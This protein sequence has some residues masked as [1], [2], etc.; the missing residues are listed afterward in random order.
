MDAQELPDGFR[1]VD[2][3]AL[4]LGVGYVVGL[5]LRL[6]RQRTWQDGY[7]A[8]AAGAQLRARLIGTLAPA[9]AR[10]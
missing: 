10:P 7:R 4:A 6:A 3:L 1:P 2:A 8:G 9:A 5:A